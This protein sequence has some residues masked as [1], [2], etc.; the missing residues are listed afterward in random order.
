[1]FKLYMQ[2]YVCIHV[3]VINEILFNNSLSGVLYMVAYRSVIRYGGVELAEYMETGIL[4]CSELR[5][6]WITWSNAN[7]R[8]GKGSELNQLTFLSYTDPVFVGI[9]FISC[10]SGYGH[11]AVWV[12]N[13]NLG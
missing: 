12:F 6:Y 9:N 11:D 4:G 10:S 3:A 1:M 8:I 13:D 5:Y 2:K 7:I